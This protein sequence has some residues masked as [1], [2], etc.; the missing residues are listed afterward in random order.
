ISR[1]RIG[2][3][4][5]LKAARKQCADGGCSSR[6]SLSNFV[7]RR[8]ESKVKRLLMLRNNQR[9]RLELGQAIEL[10][11]FGRPQRAT[12][13]ID[14]EQGSAP[15]APRVIH[16]AGQERD[17]VPHILLT[18][19]LRIQGHQFLGTDRKADAESGVAEATKKIV[20]H[21]RHFRGEMFDHSGIAD[22]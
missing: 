16:L 2:D 6:V 12:V 20:Y 13:R 9:A 10:E 3:V 18:G 21:T 15:A 8:T 14:V 19:R 1:S 11:C 22:I 4:K 5:D 17:V 7:V